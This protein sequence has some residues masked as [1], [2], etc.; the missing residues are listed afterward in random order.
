MGMTCEGS[1]FG[2]SPKNQ[3]GPFLLLRG[4]DSVFRRGFFWISNFHH[5]FFRC[6][7]GFLGWEMV[8]CFW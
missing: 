8:C 7:D 1:D 4:F 5:F 6:H 2:G 3:L